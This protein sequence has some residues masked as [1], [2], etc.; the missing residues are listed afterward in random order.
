MIKRNANPTA[1]GDEA[2]T[3]FA[4]ALGASLALH[5]ALIFGVQVKAPQQA[6]SALAALKVRIERVGDEE[7]KVTL[8]AE[9]A[10]AAVPEKVEAATPNAGEAPPS[11]AAHAA[12]VAEQAAPLLPA[13][14]IPLIE[15]PTWYPARQVDVHPTALQ[16]I[17]PVYPDKAS[18]QG[19]E[20]HV[21][22][23]LLI[24][25]AGAVK[26]V[27][28]AEAKPEGYFEESALAVFR[29]ARFS[30]AQKKG[31]AVRSRVLIRVT[32]ELE[33]HD[34]PGFQPPLP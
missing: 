10:S 32:Y 22:L 11:P 2:V 14:E 25:E 33:K 26:D 1:G 34:K 17:K 23:L 3:R 27:S 5:L 28:V 4:L 15:D 30:P 6:G 29:E 13:V 20:G 24:D 18:V 9:K 19:V 21:I 12:P 16:Q 7:R 8:T 31:R